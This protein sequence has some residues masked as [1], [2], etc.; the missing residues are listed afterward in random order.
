MASTHLDSWIGSAVDQPGQLRQQDLQPFDL[1]LCRRHRS[2]QRALPPPAPDLSLGAG[3][4]CPA[5]PPACG[6]SPPRAAGSPR[7]DG[8]RSSSSPAVLQQR[9]AL[10]D[11]V[12]A[13]LPKGGDHGLQLLLLTLLPAE[14]RSCGLLG[15]MDHPPSF[16]PNAAEICR[17][18][19][20]G[21]KGLNR[22]AATPISAN[23]R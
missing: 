15:S 16:Q 2:G 7:P 23:L 5:R 14:C 12:P 11:G 3:R 4:R 17:A 13:P 6:Q 22:I 21:S 1:R 18:R 9:G 8:C 10:R 20:R 19:V